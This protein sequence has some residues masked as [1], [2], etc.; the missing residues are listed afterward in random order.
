M[1]SLTALGFVAMALVR[2]AGAVCHFPYNDLTKS[3]AAVCFKTLGNESDFTVREYSSP[4]DGGAIIVTYNVSVDVTVYQEDFELG[5]FAV[6]EYFLG[7]NAKNESL[8]RARTTPLILRPSHPKT[9]SPWFVQMAIAPGAV[10]TP[11]APLF[12]VT[13]APLVQVDGSPLLLAARHEQLNFSPQPSDYDS[14]ALSLIEAL[15]LSKTWKYDASSP[16]SPTYAYFTG[17]MDYSGPYDIECWV[18]VQSA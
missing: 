17:Q 12:G 10:S 16:A 9:N 13:L 5:T 1:Y 6:L 11:P 15:K 14:C 3:L 18:G 4:N 8:R 2:P 7:G